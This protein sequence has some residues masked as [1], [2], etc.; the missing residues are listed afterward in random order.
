MAFPWLWAYKPTSFYI[1][2]YEPL[3]CWNILCLTPPQLQISCGRRVVIRGV[4]T[5]SMRQGA[6]K[7]PSA[8]IQAHSRQ[9]RERF[10]LFLS[11]HRCYHQIA[12]AIISVYSN[13]HND[14]LRVS[15]SRC[16]NTQLNDPFQI[17]NLKMM[18]MSHQL[19]FTGKLGFC[20]PVIIAQQCNNLSLTL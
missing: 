16:L 7:I 11:H 18:N 8:Y 12:A 1:E 2:Y 14:Y 17:F 13:Y 19:F 5:L 6:A 10:L 20:F 4:V 15:W 9:M 3:K